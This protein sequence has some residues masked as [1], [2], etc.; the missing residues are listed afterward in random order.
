VRRAVLAALF[1]LALAPLPAHAV[2]WRRTGTVVGWVRDSLSGKPVHSCL[3]V[4]SD[5]GKK[6]WFAIDST[7]GLGRFRLRLPA[8]KHWV[9]VRAYP[10]LSRSQQ[11]RVPV[12]VRPGRVDT[13]RIRILSDDDAWAM[14][15][16]TIPSDG[17][18]DS[19]GSIMG[20]VRDSLSG[21]P[22]AF[23]N[24]VILD[25]RQGTQTDASGRFRIVTV[26]AG[27][28]RVQVTGSGYHS[29][30]R[31]LV[32]RPA[33]VDTVEFRL[34]STVQLD[35]HIS[36]A[37]HPATA[38]PRDTTGTVV[39]WVRDSL[40]GRALPYAS[41]VVQGT[42]LGAM[43]DTSGWFRL[44]G[45]PAGERVIQALALGFRRGQTQVRVRTSRTDTVWLR[46]RVHPIPNMH[47]ERGAPQPGP[48]PNH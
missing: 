3:W 43:A 48:R 30:E 41:V 24:V 17:R 36:L 39:G 46:L 13:V 45:V 11:L 1:A 8:G 6:H 22:V 27:E 32:V 37:S 5:P 26:P 42:H 44:A 34:Q 10:E 9:F 23:A 47:I 18:R 31:F 21:L 40:S 19:T 33:A 2:P 38:V 15:P 16:Q 25:W 35:Y 28:H 20:W 14:R 12:L 7:D 4:S 29:V